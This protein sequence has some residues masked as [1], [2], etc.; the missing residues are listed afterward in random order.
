MNRRSFFAL[1]SPRVRCNR[2]MRKAWKASSAR[3]FADVNS[4]SGESALSRS[5]RTA[6]KYA[7]KRWEQV[8]PVR[9]QQRRPP[10]SFLRERSA[11]RDTCLAPLP[12]Q[13]RSAL[14]CRILVVMAAYLISFTLCDRVVVFHSPLPRSVFKNISLID[15]D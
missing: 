3:L 2:A 1:L 10:R 14:V 7:P 6:E 11:A 13:N 4:E 15:H 8:W 5:S 9:L 12:R